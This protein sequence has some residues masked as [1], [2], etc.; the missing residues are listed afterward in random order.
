VSAL[1]GRSGEQ[2]ALRRSIDELG[3]G[4]ASFVFVSGEPGIGKTRL[5]AELEQA[6]DAAGCT[7]LSGAAAEFE[8]EL[9]FGVFV[10][11]VDEYLE[12]L[13]PQTFSR[14]GA[15]E[16]A[17]LAAV[18]PAFRSPATAETELGTAAGRFR[19]HRAVREL[20]G[21]LARRRPV[22][23]ILDDLH[24]A[25]G[26]SLELVEHLLR[27]PGRGPLLLAG[28]YR[29]GQADGALLDAI[30]RSG[31]EQ[32]ELGPLTPADAETMGVASRLY[33][34]SGGNPFYML[35]LARGHP[36]AT[37]PA[38]GGEPSVPAAVTSAIVRELADLS[39]SSRALAQA[40]AVAGDPFE[41][42][43]AI[44]VAGTDEPAAL[45][46]LD[47]LVARDLV[48]AGSVP[49]RFRFRHPLVRSAVY[50]AC[51]AGARLA[52]HARA[53]EV[54]AARGAPAVARAHHVEQSARHGDAAAIALLRE[55]GTATAQ[56]APQSAARWF[57][58]AHELLPGSAPA[59][60]RI[61]LLT[62]LA[63]A[64]AATG[65][66]EESR[67]AMLA[68]LALTHGGDPQQRA[69]LTTGCA[70]AEQLMGDYDGA[71]ARIVEALGEFVPP[72]SPMAAELMLI[73]ASGA[74]FGL[75]FDGM[76]DWGGRAAAH[77]ER[78]G[79]ELLAVAAASV[80]A[81]A[82]SFTV[83]IDEAR[84]HCDRAAALID[85][86]PDE[87]LGHRLDAISNLTAA[88]LYLD[89]YAQCAAH[90]RRGLQLAKRTGQSEF[91]FVLVQTL[92]VS[93]WMS[94]RLEEALEV[95]DSA[96]EA[97][98]L[99]G[100]AQALAWNQLNSS[101]VLRVIGEHER[102]LTAARESVGYARNSGQRFVSCLAG[103]ALACAEI[104]AGRP[105]HG[106]ATFAACSGG[107]DLAL[108]PGAWRAYYLELAT[109]AW[110]ELG[111]VD[112]AERT[113]GLAAE[114][115]AA[116]PLPLAMATAA[117]A[118]AA[119]ALHRGEAERGAERALQAAAIAEEGG[120]R[121]EA[122][123]ARM[124]AARG[125]GRER[126]IEELERAEAEFAA[127]GARHYREQAERELGRARGGRRPGRR[128]G[129]GLQA[130]S[131][132]E[133]D[134]ARLVVER[135]TNNE[136]AERLFLSRK[137][138]ET[139]MS[140]LFRKLGVSS[141]VEVARMVERLDRDDQSSPSQ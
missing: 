92:G 62:S 8:R 10:D 70:V 117:R 87:R 6:A 47:E 136:I 135:H 52:A 99:S 59:A 22:V 2:E 48:R 95:L 63:G 56:R 36:G 26:A 41:L 81:V 97:A 137:T 43:L 105:E 39:G 140:A 38:A 85:A 13:D 124:L 25:D 53:A 122:A 141:R 11:A 100:N 12:G 83:A 102:A 139:H 17:E 125:L 109:R 27:R 5:L 28:A 78:T 91:F 138:V 119:V 61:E 101:M 65:R 72:D 68:A 134:V 112:E 108:I 113:A 1:I 115:A 46:A 74:L 54:L 118:E 107:P 51:P 15:D 116:A 114:V 33:A 127:R 30:S 84:A 64:T 104:E 96:T 19:A 55:A 80:L 14:F 86:L 18:F 44:A 88:E 89:R 126:A 50:A 49:R 90:G 42:D 94:G 111:R 45:D 73:A 133:L 129:H 128:D 37:V 110:L 4:G 66:F 67:D 7:V 31:S 103:V 3:E 60:E 82:T 121:V 123:V 130:L 29:K 79:D 24:W 21:R 93:V 77:A 120:I 35:Q 20:I 40:A 9:P 132:R 98:R 131:R 16:L 32:L 106:L 23:L 71:L 75:D 76:R 58:A 57:R 69:A 34:A